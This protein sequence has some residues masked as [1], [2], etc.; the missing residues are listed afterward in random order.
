[1]NT[2][3]WRYLGAQYADPENTRS[4]PLKASAPELDL[5]DPLNP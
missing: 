5:I 4:V 1:M 3:S 2:W